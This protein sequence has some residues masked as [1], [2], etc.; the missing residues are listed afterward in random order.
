MKNSKPTKP[1][2]AVVELRLDAREFKKE[3]A[4]LRSSVRAL[5]LD[6]RMAASLAKSNRR[7]KA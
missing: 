2:I 4:Q 5:I 3:L 6:M 1:R 7:I